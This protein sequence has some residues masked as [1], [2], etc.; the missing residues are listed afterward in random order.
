MG[1]EVRLVIDFETRSRADLKKT[2]PWVYAADPSTEVLCLAV[3]VDD[4]TNGPPRIYVPQEGLART[5]AGDVLP[6]MAPG[7]VGDLIAEADEVEAHNAEFERAVWH[8]VCHKRWGWP[9]L[10]FEKLRCSAA[11][12]S[13]CSLPRAL[14]QACEVLGLP[15]QKD[16]EG[17]RIMLRF[18][19]PQKKRDGSTYWYEDPADFVKLCR[20]CLQDVEAEYALSRA[21]PPLPP[22]ELEIWRLDQEINRR[23]IRVD[24]KAAEAMVYEIAKEEAKLL[25]E[26]RKLTDGKVSSPKQVEAFLEYLHTEFNVELDDLRKQTVA[27]AL[28]DGDE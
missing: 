22:L 5:T 26:F 7:R 6:L 25:A 2:G 14:G 9:D 15:Q 10:P 18:C 17:K 3:K 11:R 13:M 24:R 20:Y 23:G 21:L 1:E 4:V 27:D 19:K 12:A 8:H 16:M 28:E